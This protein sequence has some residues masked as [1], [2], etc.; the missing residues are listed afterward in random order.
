MTSTRGLL[1]LALAVVA[2]KTPTGTTGIVIGTTSLG[3]DAPVTHTSGA[4]ARSRRETR[5]PATS[6]G[7]I[8][9][10]G[11]EVLDYSK[12]TFPDSDEEEGSSLVE[13][14]EETKKFMQ[15]KFT[16]SVPNEEETSKELLPASQGRCSKEPQLD[17]FL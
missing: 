11:K 4:N 16:T 15:S 13:V 17:D 3:V 5:S 14:S 1:A 2:P 6:W 7:A 8:T 9:D 12:I 10:E